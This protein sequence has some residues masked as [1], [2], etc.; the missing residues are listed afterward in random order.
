MSGMYKTLGWIL[1]LSSAPLP[2][3]KVFHVYKIIKKLNRG[4][5]NRT[6]VSGTQLAMCSTIQSMASFHSNGEWLTCPTYMEWWP[7]EP[8]WE[9]LVVPGM[10][11][12]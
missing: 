8:C 2:A 5:E 6:H 11:R 4:Q 1:V 10:A 3:N 7:P 12:V 9:V